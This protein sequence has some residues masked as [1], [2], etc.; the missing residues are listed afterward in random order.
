MESLRIYI[1][2][3]LSDCNKCHKTFRY[4]YSNYVT[5][6]FVRSAMVSFRCVVNID[7]GIDMITQE[8]WKCNSGPHNIVGGRQRVASP[9]ME[10]P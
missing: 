7:L 5:V 8:V 3:E 1:S 6:L 2:A 10:D 9:P 4:C